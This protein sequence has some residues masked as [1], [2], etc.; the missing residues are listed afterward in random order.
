M[1]IYEHTDEELN[2]LHTKQLLAELNLARTYA[3]NC[4]TNEF[5][6]IP[7]EY[8]T[9]IKAILATREHIPNKRELRLIRQQKAKM[10]KCR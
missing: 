1:D 8:V 10:K 7:K 6:E 4:E 5:E 2:T 3:L 9:R